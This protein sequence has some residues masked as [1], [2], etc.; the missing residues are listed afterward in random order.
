MS[1][2][3]QPDLETIWA[4][5]PPDYYFKLNYFQNLWHEWKWMILKYLMTRNNQQPKKILE[6]GCAAGHL[7]ALI[8]SVFPKA[9]VI[10]IDVYKDAVVEAK[11]RYPKLKFL[12]ADAHKLPFKNQSFDLVVSSETIEHVVDPSLMLSEIKRVLKPKGHAI[13]EMDSGS[14]LF[15]CIWF[16]WSNF[17]KGRV[18]H[19]A[20][21]HPFRGGELES[22]ILTRGFNITEK[23]FSHFGMAVSF[24]LTH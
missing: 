7:T 23:Q 24:L 10:G 22:L 4:Q 17:G 21:L 5:V 8:A 19:D 14:L 16:V 9:E 1:N 2:L 11:A 15:R 12:V 3:K 20:H 18:W 6:V 13:V